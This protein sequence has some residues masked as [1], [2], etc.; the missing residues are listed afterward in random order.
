MNSNMLRLGTDRF[1]LPEILVATFEDI[2]FRVMQSGVKRLVD[3]S[4]IFP[5][6]FGAAKAKKGGGRKQK[7]KEKA[8]QAVSLIARD[9]D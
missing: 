9:R 3:G 8:I 5:Q 1:L 4:V 7:E 6:D 2:D